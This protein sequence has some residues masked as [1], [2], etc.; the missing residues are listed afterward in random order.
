MLDGLQ[1][2]FIILYELACSATVS[3]ATSECVIRRTSAIASDSVV[4]T[5]PGQ[6]VPSRSRA[7]SVPPSKSHSPTMVCRLG[8]LACNLLQNV[9]ACVI[10]KGGSDEIQTTL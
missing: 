9:R 10:A 2:I 1:P 6:P 5:T 4:A 8:L 7:F 3:A